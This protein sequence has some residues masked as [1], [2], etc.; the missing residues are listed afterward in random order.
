MSPQAGTGQA[1]GYGLGNYVT[2]LDFGAGLPQ[3]LPQQ[4]D[5][6]ASSRSSITLDVSLFGGYAFARFTFPGK[7]SCSC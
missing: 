3:Y 4:R 2:L 1:I 5:R 6:L 7:N